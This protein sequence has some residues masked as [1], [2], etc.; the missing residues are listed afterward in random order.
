MSARK[1]A[2]AGEPVYL[3][4]RCNSHKEPRG[5]CGAPLV[6]RETLEA[7]VER[8]LRNVLGDRDELRRIFQAGAERERTQQVAAETAALSAERGRVLE[9]A[10]RGLMGIDEADEIISELR[11][12]LRALAAPV[13]LRPCIYRPLRPD[14][15]GTS[16]GIASLS[17]SSA[18]TTSKAINIF[19]SS[20][21]YL[22]SS[23]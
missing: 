19:L 13:E 16:F 12:K 14:Y 20:Q 11:A 17:S 3:Y 15:F 1:V 5:K 6:R 9:L 2:R 21:R 22:P 10:R 8:E 4:Y 18:K 7:A 23:A